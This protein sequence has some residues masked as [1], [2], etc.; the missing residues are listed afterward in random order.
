MSNTL[1]QYGKRNAAFASFLALT[2]K[3]PRSAKQRIMISVMR[4]IFNAGWAARKKAEYETIMEL[5]K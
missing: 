3:R 5:K 2:V 1:D 4:E